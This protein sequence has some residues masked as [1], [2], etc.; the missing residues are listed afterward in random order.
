MKTHQLWVIACTLLITV[1]CNRP[2]DKA[3]AGIYVTQFRNQYSQTNDTLVVTAYNL[4]A[5][6]YQIERHSGFNRIRDGKLLPRE[7]KQQHWVATYREGNMVLEEG[8]LG[9]KLY[10]KP[11]EQELVM[12]KTIY[13]LMKQP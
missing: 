6:T 9:R 11:D 10:V 4:A 1:A 7:F 3:I 5:H 2:Q 12:G 8:D 13:Q